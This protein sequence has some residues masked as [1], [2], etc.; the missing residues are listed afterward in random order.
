MF[1]LRVRGQCTR[2]TGRKG[3]AVGVKKVTLRPTAG[4]PG[5]PAEAKEGS[6]AA[7]AAGAA[8]PEASAPKGSAPKS[9]ETKE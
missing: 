4:G 7:P 5:A 3:G 6:A 2:T 1:G 9:P 8:T